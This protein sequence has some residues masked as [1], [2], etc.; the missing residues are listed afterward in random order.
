MRQEMQWY[1]GLHVNVNMKILFCQI[2]GPA[3]AESAGPVP[4]RPCD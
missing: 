1:K 3:A 4:I 2:I